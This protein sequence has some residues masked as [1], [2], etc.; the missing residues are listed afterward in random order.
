MRKWSL[1]AP[2]MAVLAV[3]VGVSAG[4]SGGETPP[5]EPPPPAVTSAPPTA[6]ASRVDLRYSF[7]GELTESALLPLRVVTETGGE[8]R[9]V[10]HGAGMA[11]RFPD[12]CTAAEP[13]QCPRA[14]LESAPAPM[15]NPDTRPLRYGAAVRIPADQVVNGANVLQKG[16]SASGSQFKLQVDRGRPSCVVVDVTRQEIHRAE[17]SSRIVDGAWHQLDCTRGGDSLTLTVDGKPAGRA[18]VPLDLSIVNDEP[19]R[20]GG[21]GISANNDQFSG[22][23]D[24]VYIAVA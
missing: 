18:T 1:F 22:E 17:G 15:L 20:I 9:S 23:I 16:F 3:L 19:L 13:K 24:D 8:V 7:D 4:C 5:A 10:P 11:V 21:K 14:I 2:I 12:R 6:A